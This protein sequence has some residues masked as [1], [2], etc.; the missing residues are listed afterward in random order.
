VSSLSSGIYALP[1][2][3]APGYLLWVQGGD[4]LAQPFDAER[5]TLSGR[6][7]TIA[8]DVR[9]LEGQL[10]MVVSAAHNGTLAWASARAA[11]RRFSWLDRDGRRLETLAIEE[12]DVFQPTISPDGNRLLY[13]RAVNGTA[14]IF[15]YDFAA[16]RTRRVTMSPDYDEQPRWSPDGTEMVYSSI[17]GGDN[18]LLRVPL[19]GSAPPVNLMRNPNQNTPSV[20]TPDGRYLVMSMSV[21]EDGIDTFLLPVDGAGT[22]TPLLAGPA[23]DLAAMFS[24]DGRWLAYVSNRSGRVETYVVRFHGDRS[25]PAIAGAPVQITSDGGRIVAGGWRKDGREIVVRS[26]DGQVMA[27]P[28]DTRGESVTTGRPVALFRP[29]V[30]QASLQMAPDGNRFLVTELPYAAGQTIRVLTNWRERLRN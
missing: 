10:G 9:I 16:R 27:V 25:P 23:N 2:E 26:A 8:T 12:G 13:A 29:S 20:W 14:D 19:D 11:L 3:G 7:A 21:S 24:G 22:L 28:V 4:L 5:A 6:P 30:D 15:L 17:Q 1:Y 18:G